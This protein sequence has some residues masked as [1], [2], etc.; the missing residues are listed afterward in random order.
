MI[1][2][3]ETKLFQ[4]TNSSDN[5]TYKRLPSLYKTVKLGFQLNY[6]TLN[7]YSCILKYTPELTTVNGTSKLQGD[8]PE[9]TH[10]LKQNFILTP[11]MTN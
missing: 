8:C 6:S 10:S 11:I 5:Q 2:Q 9:S 1:I 4:L 7:Y 3:T